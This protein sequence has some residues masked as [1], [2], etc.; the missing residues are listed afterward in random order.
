MRGPLRAII[1][2]FD[3][4]IADTEPYHLRA[5][6]Q[7]LAREGIVLTETDYYST[8]L[9]MDD[10]ECFRSVLVR[11]GR[12]GGARKLSALIRA[13]SRL[14]TASVRGD[15]TFTPGAIAFVKKASRSYPLAI[16]S[17]ALHREIL[18]I[19]DTGGIANAFPVIISAEDIRK[20]KPDP[21]GFISALRGINAHLRSQGRPEDPVAPGECLVI[22]DS[23]FGIEAARRAGMPC[24]ALAT[25]YD[26]EELGGACA[27]RKDLRGLTLAALARLPRTGILRPG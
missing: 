4:V 11:H 26:E 23:P 6:Q 17:G 15:L 7:V 10:R 18:M 9:G 5:F 1:F 13:K 3:G 12:R 14:F 22:E 16:A 27:V 21:E 2:D 8:Y 25:S 20:G 24:L 19:L